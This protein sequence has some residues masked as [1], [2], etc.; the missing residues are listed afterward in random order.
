[1]MENDA[2]DANDDNAAIDEMAVSEITVEGAEDVCPENNLELDAILKENLTS[3]VFDDDPD[4]ILPFGGPRS[5]TNSSGRS[6]SVHVAPSTVKKNEDKKV[7]RRSPVP[8]I[9]LDAPRP[10]PTR[11]TKRDASAS[12]LA[13]Y[14]EAQTKDRM[15]DREQQAAIFRAQLAQNQT[16]LEI[17]RE[18]RIERAKR[19]EAER[20]Y[21]EE[22]DREERKEREE[23]RR[24]EKEE[25]L[26]ARQ[27]Q[28]QLLAAILN[29]Q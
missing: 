8:R 3:S 9:D 14:T 7:V 19:D 15:L 5:A 12:A 18:D 10:T 16:N 11:A 25:Q 28:M 26:A 27:M 24:E 1:M 29:R 22:R 23:R 2:N 17:A 20:R 4:P 6:S 13:A 21:R